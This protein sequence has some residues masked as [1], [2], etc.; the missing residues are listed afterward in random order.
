M[1]LHIINYAVRIVI[2]ILGIIMVS[3]I[4]TPPRENA[5]FFTIMGV[6]FIL[7]GLYRLVLYRFKS[8]R[9]DFSSGNIISKDDEDEEEEN[10]KQ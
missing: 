1:Y 6:V 2:I 9:Y 5:E 4:I 8:Q 7:F 10:D 3:G